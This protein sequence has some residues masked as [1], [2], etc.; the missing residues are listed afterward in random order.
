MLKMLPLLAVVVCMLVIPAHA[1]APAK[2]SVDANHS[3]VG[4]SVPI[5]D[6]LSSVSGKFSDF[7]VTINYDDADITKSSVEA[8]IKA[9]SINTGVENRD[10]HLRTADFFDVEKFPEITFKSSSVVKKGKGFVANGTFTMHGVSKEISIPFVRSGTFVNPANNKSSLGFTAQL[11]LKR[12]DYGITWQHQS[13]KNWVGD[14]VTI[15]L[16]VLVRN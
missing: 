14:V 5:L 8:V 12:S 7:A 4:F 9:A 13:I 2:Y 11:Q 6:G 3:T 1:V 10:K 15:N 16:A